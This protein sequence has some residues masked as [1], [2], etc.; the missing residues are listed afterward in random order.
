MRRYTI[1]HG[2]DV[3]LPQLDEVKTGAFHRRYSS[4]EVLLVLRIG[5]VEAGGR[6]DLVANNKGDFPSLDLDLQRR[7]EGV[8]V[9][10]L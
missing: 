6:E 7:L 9:Y 1:D 10:R 3:L 2:L 5:R 4:L 8:E